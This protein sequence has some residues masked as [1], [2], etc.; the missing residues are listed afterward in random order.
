G[1]GVL[2]GAV[3]GSFGRGT[4]AAVT[5][6]ADRMREALP[7]CEPMVSG[8]VNAAYWRNMLAYMDWLF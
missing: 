1:F 6:L 8:T 2:D 3:D 4:E 7:G 5:L